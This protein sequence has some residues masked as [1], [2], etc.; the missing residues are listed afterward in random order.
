MAASIFPGTAASSSPRSSDQAAVQM[1]NVTILSIGDIRDMADG[2]A[3][4][5]IV[6]K[7]TDMV[8]LTGDGSTNRWHQGD[9]HEGFTLYTWHDA[10][11]VVTVEI[12]R[13]MRQRV[14]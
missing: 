13:I 10:R 2:E 12:S 7:E 9:C 6:G 3:A 4:L 5:K 14:G 11:Q 1:A 8:I